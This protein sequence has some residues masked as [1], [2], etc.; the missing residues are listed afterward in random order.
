MRLKEF[1]PDLLTALGQGVVK[2]ATGASSSD[3]NKPSS[4]TGLD[5]NKSSG[6]GLDP[7]K[8]G[9]IGLKAP[10]NG[11]PVQGG[12]VSSNFGMRNGKNHPGIDIA[13]PVG[14]PVQCPVDGV[15]EVATSHPDAG[16][17][18]NVK[19]TDGGK[20]RFLHLSKINVKAGDKI[21]AG[22]V[23]GLSGNTGRSTG[24]HLHWE[25]WKG[26]DYASASNP[27]SNVG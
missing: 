5:P 23:I 18:V 26:S 4:G 9:G 22:D 12:K 19:T 10:E 16:N 3:I 14:T 27:L 6:F 25:K 2:S 13:V 20:Q 1:A 17:Y 8:K 24:P 21:S 11:L 15:V 7:E